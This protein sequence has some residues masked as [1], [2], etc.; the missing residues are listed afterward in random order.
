[1]SEATT[2]PCPQC[3]ILQQQLEALQQQVQNLQATI[4]KLQTQLAA[5][6]KNSSTSSKPPSS[7]LVKPTSRTDSPRAACGQP[8]HP[9][10]QLVL[11]PPEALNGGCHSHHLPACPACAHELLDPATA[12]RTVEQRRLKDGA[13]RIA[14]QRG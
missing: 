6:S 5:K 10:H 13:S 11:F 9:H 12:S 14:D 7:D 8:R 3:S 2:T 1:M 4:D